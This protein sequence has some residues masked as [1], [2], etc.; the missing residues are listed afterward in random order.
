M[1]TEDRTGGAI[2]AKGTQN[3]KIRDKEDTK[4]VEPP[5]LGTHHNGG[6]LIAAGQ[7]NSSKGAENLSGSG[8]TGNGAKDEGASS[9][10][11]HST[12]DAN[13]ASFSKLTNIIGSAEKKFNERSALLFGTNRNNREKSGTSTT[14]TSRGLGKLPSFFL[15]KKKKK[16]VNK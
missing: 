5:S 10:G 8:N 13:I 3:K 16:K 15:A 2:K 6:S 9:D 14:K 11:Y 7:E 1:E 12:K 4:S